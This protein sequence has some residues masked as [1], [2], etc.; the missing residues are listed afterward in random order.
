M[1]GCETAATMLRYGHHCDKNKPLAFEYDSRA[2]KQG[3][4]ASCNSVRTNLSVPA[5]LLNGFVTSM[6]ILSLRPLDVDGPGV[7]SLMALVVKKNF[8]SRQRTSSAMSTACQRIRS[9]RSNI[10]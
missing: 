2:C 8:R 6:L 9:R 5:T 7:C 10:V 4:A 3:H 1:K